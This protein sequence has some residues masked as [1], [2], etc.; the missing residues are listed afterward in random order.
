MRRLKTAVR[1]WT[2]VRSRAAH[3]HSI[4]F[5]LCLAA[6]LASPAAYAATFDGHSGLNTNWSTPTNWVGNVVPVSGSPNLQVHLGSSGN[7]NLVSSNQD[8]AAPFVLQQLSIGSV[9]TFTPHTVTGSPLAFSNLGAAP[10]IFNNDFVGPALTINSDIDL[11]ADVSVSPS[12]SQ[13]GGSPTT[14]SLNG[15][16]S[17]VGGLRQTGNGDLYLGGTAANTYAG[18]TTTRGILRLTKAPSVIAVPG[19]LEIYGSSSTRDARGE[20]IVLNDNQIAAD[21]TVTIAG[22]R[23]SVEGGDQT[24]ARVE[25]VGVDSFFLNQDGGDIV[26]SPSR[27]LTI[28]DGITR[29]SPSIPLI[30]PRVSSLITGGTLNLGGGLRTFHVD[31]AN[32]I[33]LP[34][35]LTVRSVIANG[36]IE[37]TGVGVLHLSEAK[38]TFT[39]NVLVTGG[40]FSVGQNGG[41]LFDLENGGVSN[42]ILGTANAFLNGIFRIDAASVTDVSGSWNLVDVANL[43]ESFGEGLK[44]QFEGGL[45]FSNNGAGVYRSGR[46]TFTTADGNLTLSA[47]PEPTSTLLTSIGLIASGVFRRALVGGRRAEP[48]FNG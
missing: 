5:A 14:F 29:T 47:V 23:L 19:D 31:D 26:I 11:N 32:P 40:M 24:L 37:K 12:R 7:N 41:L 21:A 25:F 20:V 45:P 36:G 39:G 28:T 22:G 13:S 4:I 10:S 16:I 30:F 44:L 48:A 42:R 2:P 38:N 1:R 15:A 8:L 46:W 9:G 43:N 33:G 35:T 18:L 6:Q 17:G 3:S 27:T 34:T